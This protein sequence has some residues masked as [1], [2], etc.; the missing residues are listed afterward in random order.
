M[1]VWHLLVDVDIEIMANAVIE[2]IKLEVA[3]DVDLEETFQFLITLGGAEALQR[4]LRR[5]PPAQLSLMREKRC[6]NCDF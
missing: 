5:N 1:N 4:N 3:K 6:K 2:A